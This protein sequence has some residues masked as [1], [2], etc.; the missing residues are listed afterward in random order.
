MKQDN[1][2]YQPTYKTSHYSSQKWDNSWSRK[3][4][5]FFGSKGLRSYGGYGGFYS[6]GGP[7]NKFGNLLRQKIM[8]QILVSILIFMVAVAT[9]NG[10][11]PIRKTVASSFD[12]LL[13]T[14]INYEPILGKIVKIA[15][16]NEV[17]DWPVLHNQSEPEARPVQGK[18]LSL[19]VSGSLIKQYGWQEDPVDNY[20]RFHE[21]ID[22][23][24]KKGSTVQVVLDGKITKVGQDPILG[25]YVQVHHS[26]ELSTLYAHLSEVTVKTDE[27]IKE[28]EQV[29]KVGDTGIA[30]E[31]HL[32]FEVRES[33]QLVDPVTRLKLPDKAGI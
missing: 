5:G 8:Y 23:K 27:L 1:S 15:L 16:S 13:K 2:N 31:P 9:H 24:A 21:G 17:L 30:D 14:E 12:Y 22:I 10:Q 6:T 3:R 25:K 4:S 7:P 19:P 32:H 20:P 28:G 33:G 26:E 11:D 18:V 29:G